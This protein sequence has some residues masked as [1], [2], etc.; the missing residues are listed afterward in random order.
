LHVNIYHFT[1]SVEQVRDPSLRGRP[2][3][4]AQAG[5]VR[6]RVQDLSR[7]AFEEG[8]R[9]GMWLSD[10][11]RF[12]RGVTV[13]PP[14]PEICG[15]AMA[16]VERELGAF[17][18]LCERAGAGHAFLDVSGT[19]RLFGPAVDLAHRIRRLLR[20]KLRLGAGVGTAGNKLMSKVATRVIKP[21]GLCTVVHGGE[22]MFLDPLPVGIIPGLDYEIMSRLAAFNIQTVG[23]LASMSVPELSVPFGNS[24]RYILMRASGEDHSPVFPA[25]RPPPSVSEERTLVPDTND[26]A[27]IEKAV[28]S[29]AASAGARLRRSGM[30]PGRARMSVSYCDG[31]RLRGETRLQGGSDLDITLFE[32]LAAL[33]LKTAGVKISGNHDTYGVPR[34]SGPFVPSSAKRVSRDDG[35]PLGTNGIFGITPNLIPSSFTAGSTCGYSPSSALRADLTSTRAAP[36][37]SSF[38]PHPSSL[39]S[40]TPVRRVRIRR[41]SVV[42]DRM[43]Y[44]GGQMD[45]FEGPWTKERNLMH[46]LDSV[47]KRFGGGALKWGRE[48]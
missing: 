24:A 32:K 38:S 42:L 5:L 25:G 22:R 39:L 1:A 16:A 47:K 45:L 9:R 48:A 7:E 35:P 3:V 4:M 27:E 18:P 43:S 14:D 12:C 8:V 21:D 40:T 17:S 29:I 46:A 44:P 13:V 37:D 10:A 26:P 20:E 36:T 19:R 30:A 34:Y 2:V 41:I 6:A 15:R 33:Y 31:A 23:Q 11:V 28:F